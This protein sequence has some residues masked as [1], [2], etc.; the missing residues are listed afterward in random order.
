MNNIQLYRKKARLQQQELARKIGVS[1]STMSFYES[2][3]RV[4][5]FD[6]IGALLRELKCDFKDLFPN[7]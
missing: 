6:R 4:P 1:P 5:S 2:G 3:F 7:N